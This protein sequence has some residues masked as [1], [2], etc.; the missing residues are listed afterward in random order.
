[1]AWGDAKDGCGLRALAAA[2][3]F[4]LALALGTSAWADEPRARIDGVADPRLL[5]ELREAIGRV[6]EAPLS[7]LDAR[8]R[9]NE[10]AERAVVVLR[11]EGY[12]QAELTPDVTD[13]DPPQAVLTV[14]LGQRFL[15]GP[16]VIQWSGAPP[17]PEAQ[18]AATEAGRVEP[19]EPGRAADVLAAEGRVVASLQ[20]QGYP[21]AAAQPRRVVVDHADF[22]VQPTFN[23]AAGELVRLDGILFTTRGRTRPGEVERLIPWHAGD[24]YSPGQL[25]ELE[26]R[27]LDV[28]V[29]QS[30]TVALAPVE[31]TTTG[32]LRPVV[33]SL[34]DRRP[35][36]I[37]LGGTYST[38][39]GLGVDA[40]LTL[41]NRLG[42]FDTETLVMQVAQI[43]QKVDFEVS[44]PNWRRPAQR[45]RV[46]AG[47]YGNRTDAY[48][49]RG[50]GVRAD[51]ER[52]FG[53]QVFNTVG[54]YATVG[55]SLDY[56]ST[57]DKTLANPSWQNLG[58][59]SLLGAFAVDHSDNALDPHRG[60]RAEARAEPTLITGDVSLV[61]LKTTL[62]GAVY[63]PIGDG[64]VLASRLRVGSILG[65]ALP[66]V[67]G[68]R[69]LFAGGG[70]SVRG[71]A[72]QGVGPRN[73]NNTPQ[74][75]LSLVEGSLEYRRRLFGNWGG[76]AFVDAGAVSRGQIPDF[77][78]LSVGVGL[79]VRYD[80]GFGPIRVDVG[81]PLNRREGDPA[82]QVYISIGQAF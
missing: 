21:D 11:S 79:G 4:A 66:D 51:V 77:D 67:P 60:W 43:A 82:F 69:R 17:A 53:R 28:G 56:L 12:Y 35:R 48:N 2:A 50:A 45:L 33:V 1:L 58:L 18:E 54:T 64:S 46:G 80:L 74:G 72:Y 13:S 36:T 22:T 9:A 81:V 16:S 61:Y 24:K 6:R 44:L 47:L 32:G 40:R 8:R 29:Y 23:I 42:R 5:A 19:G 59:L 37:E 3:A 78:N 10:A 31:Q 57:F 26:R 38:T 20:Q 55:V 49:D 25:S 62:Q 65:G 7:R 71:Y 15:F 73:A 63:L 75:G 52:R 39:D 68:S 41:Y 30:V 70:G 27:L 76:V 14:N 34:A